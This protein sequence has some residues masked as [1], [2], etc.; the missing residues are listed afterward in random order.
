MLSGVIFWG[1]GGQLKHYAY[2]ALHYTHFS[3]KVEKKVLGDAYQMIKK[4]VE[5]QVVW[6]FSITP[7]SEEWLLSW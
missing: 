4:Q 2:L 7:K 1:K 3:S 5:M 6:D